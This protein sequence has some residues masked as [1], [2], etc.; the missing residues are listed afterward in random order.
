V[1]ARDKLAADAD[2]RQVIAGGADGG[3]EDA[4]GSELLGGKNGVREKWGQSPFS[5]MYSKSLEPVV[6]KG[7]DPIFF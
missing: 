3:E 1:P 6:K 7:S 5:W 4:Q 2:E